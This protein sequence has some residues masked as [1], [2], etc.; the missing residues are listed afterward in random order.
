[1][2][3]IPEHVPVIAVASGKGGVGKT[4]VAVSGVVCPTCG[5]TTPLFPA[6]PDE[7]SIWSLVP[8]LASRMDGS[9]QLEG[10]P[11]LAECAAGVVRTASLLL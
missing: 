1:M 8:K 10:G 4:T 5:Q 11:A 2:P 9:R 3:D 7:E 6:A